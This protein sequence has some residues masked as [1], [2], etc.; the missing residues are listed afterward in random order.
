MKSSLFPRFLSLLAVLGSV[1]GTLRAADAPAAP[2]T[3]AP[4]V[5]LKLDD[6]VRSAKKPDATVSP[7]FQKVT[8][9]L[10][11]EKIKGS[12]GI[13]VDSLE[14]DCP[15]YVAWLKQRITNGYIQIW[16][17][18]YYSRVPD[19]IK[20]NGRTAENEGAPADVQAELFKKTVALAKEKLGI[21][22]VA[23]G[24]HAT[25]TDAATY[26]A[27]EGIPEIKMVWFYPPPKGAKS[28]KVIIKRLME[29]E[30]PIFHPN[31]EQFKA[32]FEAKRATLPYVA[33]QGHP[34]SWD[35]ASYEEFKKVVLYLREQGCKFVTPSEYLASLPKQ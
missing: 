35:D 33:I 2:S 28:S 5:L 18:G 4:V 26:E 23:F 10:E 1:A 24:P 31:F 20:V 17:H 29:L 14:G 12:F 7:R 27:L 9:F 25:H 22:L 21:D 30:K 3:A 15:A 19:E 8:D 6:L 32:S 13:L 16:D 11:S 34:N